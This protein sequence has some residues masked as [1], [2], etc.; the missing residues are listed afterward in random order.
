MTTPPDDRSFSELISNGLEQVTA[1]FRS[2]IQLAKAEM[3]KKASKAG[4]A[5][6]LMVCGLAFA[7]ATLVMLLTTIA[8]FL[9]QAGLGGGVAFLLATVV[10]GAIAAILAWTGI[11]KLKSET[12]VPERTVHQVQ[13][14]AQAAKGNQS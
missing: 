11:Q 1:L 2:E 7:I 4:L 9:I 13:M 10:G 5:I 3:A 12:M 14:D 8:T 6:G